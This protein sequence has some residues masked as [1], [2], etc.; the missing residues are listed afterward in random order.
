LAAGWLG[1]GA[2]VGAGLLV[3]HAAAATAAAKVAKEIAA[4]FVISWK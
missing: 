2:E 3:V 1:A 4:R